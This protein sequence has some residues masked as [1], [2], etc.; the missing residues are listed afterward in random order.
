MA[1]IEATFEQEHA[2]AVVAELSR[3]DIDGLEWR[4]DDRSDSG[5]R[6]GVTP[7]MPLPASM[8]GNGAR[9][10]DGG[11]AI[12]AP[13]VAGGADADAGSDDEE[14]YLREARSRGATLIRVDVPDEF[15]SA[16][17]GLFARHSA[18]NIVVS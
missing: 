5:A 11:P 12:V 1:K 9:A 13:F 4:V 6:G 10:A 14:S 18:S 15:E 2:D 8:A 17:R 7:I 16:I 3:M